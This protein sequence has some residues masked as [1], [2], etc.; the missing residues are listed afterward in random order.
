MCRS[1]R[2]HGAQHDAHL[3]RYGIVKHGLR[4]HL[5]SE[6]DAAVAVSDF[7]DKAGFRPVGVLALE[8]LS[9]E[10]CLVGRADFGKRDVV[11]AERH[12]EHLLQ[13]L[14][15]ADFFCEPCIVRHGERA[16]VIRPVTQMFH[17]EVV[18]FAIDGLY[19]G[20]QTLEIGERKVVC[21]FYGVERLEL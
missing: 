2:E 18:R 15:D 13:L 5:V 12:A 17:G 11:Y 10:D 21:K 8:Y 1:V 19:H 3:C 9:G 7:L 14:A 16:A 20:V 6:D 4:F